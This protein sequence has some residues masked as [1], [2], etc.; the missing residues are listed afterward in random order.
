LILLSSL[1]WQFYIEEILF[2]CNGHTS[3]S[4]LSPGFIHIIAYQKIFFKSEWYSMCIYIYVYIYIHTYIHTIWYLYY[5]LYIATSVLC[6]NIFVHAHTDMQQNFLSI[7]PSMD[8]YIASN[9]DY[10]EIATMNMEMQISP[11]FLFQLFCPEVTLLSHIGVL[12]L[13]FWGE[14]SITCN[15]SL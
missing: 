9:L 2:F 5:V 13:P 10:C 14:K 7:Y 1:L 15:A 6:I 12:F 4:I 8:V 3:L 11:R